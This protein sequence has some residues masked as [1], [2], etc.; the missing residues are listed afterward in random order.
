MAPYGSSFDESSLTASRANSSALVRARLEDGRLPLPPDV[1]G[2]IRKEG[3]DIASARCRTDSVERSIDGGG[4]SDK[5]PGGDC[6]AELEIDDIWDVFE[7]ER[8]RACEK[9]ATAASPADAPGRA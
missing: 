2:G 6:D 9:A 1:S 3:L 5:L 7:E 8:C 4:E